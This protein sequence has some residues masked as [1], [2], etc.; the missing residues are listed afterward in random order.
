MGQV[1]TRILKQSSDRPS[2]RPSDKA[3]ME[4][5]CGVDLDP[6]KFENDYPV[7]PSLTKVTESP[8]MLIDFSHHSCLD[9]LLTFGLARCVP[10]VICTTG[11]SPSQKQ[12][13]NDAAKR[14]PILNAPNMALG[15][16]LIVSLAQQAAQILHED[17]DIEIVEKHHNQKVDAPSGT[18]LMIA[19]AINSSLNDS[20]EFTFGRHSKTDKRQKKELGIHAVRGGAIV[21]EHSVIFA[22]PGEVIEINHSAISRDVFA[23]GAL[24]AA[25]FLEGQKPGLYSMK[26]VI[27]S[28]DD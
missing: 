18:A 20:L 27:E 25:R 23:Y 10:L 7:Y 26:D 3:D 1:I 16:N 15:V 19:G 21:G 14:I 22:G 17:F 2:D 5:V 11:F 4:I 12:M 24:R 8:D 9:G 13:M 6:L 28:S